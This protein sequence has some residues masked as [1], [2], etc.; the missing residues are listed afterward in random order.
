MAAMVRTRRQALRFEGRRRTDTETLRQQPDTP[1]ASTGRMATRSDTVVVAMAP[2]TTTT[3][4]SLPSSASGKAIRKQRVRDKH[5]RYTD[6]AA[7]Q[8]DSASQGGKTNLV[9]DIPK[10]KTI[11][12]RN[13]TPVQSSN[14]VSP[15]GTGIPPP[16]HRINLRSKGIFSPPVSTSSPCCADL[17]QVGADQAKDH[18]RTHP[19]LQPPIT[20]IRLCPLNPLKSLLRL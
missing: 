15:S 10:T 11:T 1:R 5:G 13:N 19:P 6:V 9:I 8:A 2:H 12:G 4:S 16:R 3:A 7:V 14:G 20:K 18:R 17:H